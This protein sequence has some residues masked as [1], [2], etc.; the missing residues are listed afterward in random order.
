MAWQY[1]NPN[2]IIQRPNTGD[3]VIRAIAKTFNYS[4]ERAYAE[5]TVQGFQMGDWGNANEVW[6]T[7]LRRNGFNRQVIPNT[8]PSCYTVWDFC[9]DNPTGKYILATGSHVVSVINGD[10]YDSWDSGKEVPIFFY[11]RR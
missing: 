2:P 1:Y 11:E 6:D 7:Y 9:N 5:L 10:Y 8:C 4:W 3:C